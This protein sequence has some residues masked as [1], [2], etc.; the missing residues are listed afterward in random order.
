MK[1]GQ[2]RSW[3]KTRRRSKVCLRLIGISLCGENHPF[4][5][6]PKL[7]SFPTQCYAWEA[8][9]LNQF[10][11]GKTTLN[12][13]WQHVS[14]K[15]WIGSAGNKWN[16]SGKFFQ[17]SLHWEFSTRFKRWW[18]NQSV[19]LSN[20]KE[21]SSSCPCTMRLNGE[22]GETEKIVLRMLTELQSMLEDTDVGHI[23]D[24]VVRKSGTEPMSTN[25]MEIGTKLLNKWCSTLQKA[26]IRHF[27]SPA[28]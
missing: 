24:L 12:G 17:D 13:I 10:K 14:L 11:F 28:L 21:G 26:V 23:W 19:N 8:F 2:L 25:L 15:I 3:S 7:T 6:N 1:F 16:S 9:V 4:C 22:N 5:A 20:S 27:G 18:R